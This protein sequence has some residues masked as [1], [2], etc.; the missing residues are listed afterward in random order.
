MRS[1]RLS[2]LTITAVWSVAALAEVSGTY[3]RDRLKGTPTPL[4]RVVLHHAPGWFVWV[5]MTPAILWLGQRFPL[6]RPV[7]PVAIVVHVVACAVAITIHVAVIAATWGGQQAFGPLLADWFP[8]SLILYVTILVAGYA[9]ENLRRASTLS[10]ELAQA[11]LSALRAQ[12]HPHFLFNALN[13]AVGLVRAREP[14]EGV[15][16][17]TDLS[18]LLRHLLQ[19]TTS[20]EIPLRDELALL[21][22]YLAIERARFGE[23]LTTSVDAVDGV[24]NALVPSMVLQPLVENAVRHGVARRE[25]PV[26]VRIEAFAESNR[27]HLRVTDDGPGLPIGWTL[28]GA[29][30]VGLKNTRARLAALYGAGG[31]LDLERAAGGGVQA[32]ILIPLRQ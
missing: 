31:S 27:L 26:H 12:L 15:R 19:D 9:I 14:E 29:T 22:R 8:F 28:D 25:A 16:V 4:W 32:D 23:R 18:E 21:Y 13:A 17:L 20:Q 2:M 6:R 10:A 11:Q 5:L 3:V 7:R 30:G 24:G 1:R